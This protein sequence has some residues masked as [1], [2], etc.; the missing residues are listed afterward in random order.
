MCVSD[1]FYS[2][3][4]IKKHASQTKINANGRTYC[5][6]RRS[7]KLYT[8]LLLIIRPKS[9]CFNRLRNFRTFLFSIRLCCLEI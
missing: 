2:Q 4:R 6:P 5:V 7:R 3:M 9:W 1:D 8:Q